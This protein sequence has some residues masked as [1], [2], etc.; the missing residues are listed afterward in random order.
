MATTALGLNQ[1]TTASGSQSD[2]TGVPDPGASKLDVE[3]VHNEFNRLKQ[4]SAQRNT[5]YYLLRQAVKGNFR[6]PRT[7]PTHIQK[8][9]HNFCK[10]ITERFAA[11][12]MSKGFDFTVDRPNTVEFRESAERAEK[13]LRKLFDL[14]GAPLQFEMGAKSG[15]QVGRTI[16]KVYRKGPKGAE[17]ACFSY[18]QPDYFYGVPAGTNQLG[19][20]ATVYYSYPIDI[21]TARQVYGDKPFKTEAELSRSNFYDLIPEQQASPTAVGLLHQRRVPVFEA[22]TNDYYLLEV[23]GVTIFNGKNPY[24]WSDTGEGFI[25][26]IVIENIRNSGD[27]IGEA[28]IEQVRELNEVYNQLVSRKNHIVGRWLTPTLVWEGA[29]SN[30]VQQLQS[31]IGG[32]GGL[33]TRIGSRL[34]FLEHASPNPQV[35]ELQQELRQAILESAGMNEIALQG[36]VQGS[37]NTGPALESQYQ[38]VLATID[39]KR[40]EWEG[41]LRLLCRMM[42]QVQE[43][44]GASKAL[45]QAVVNAS[46]DSQD[47]DGELVALSGKD[48]QGLRD[49]T[50]SWPGVLPKD[51]LGASRFELEKLQTGVQSIFTTMSNL[52]MD[53]PD[54]ELARMRDENADPQLK[55]QA[56][57]D[58]MKAQAQAQQAQAGAQS[59]QMQAMQAMQQMAMAQQ[60]GQQPQGG[61]EPE[62]TNT[63]ALPDE[64][65][66]LS[67][68]NTGAVIRELRRRSAAKFS[69]EGDQPEIQTA[70]GY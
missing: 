36:T 17:H 57:A 50:I 47:S 14:S 24:K 63:A 45:G 67:Q 33:S 10:A 70:A 12:L 51:D 19:E 43:D 26:Y 62:P 15:S 13:I 61:P 28:D 53:Y 6:W 18:C 20:Y 9:K 46:M 3:R 37:I 25:P 30:Y 27:G 64:R 16:Y 7:W 35:A 2:V 68:G 5:N 21:E 41:Q 1:Y 59:Q 23:G 40:K 55:G 31:V 22:W 49:V 32:G 56:V 58:Q 65:T 52:G 54:D 39:N 4:Q 38:P 29:P 42:L 44:I 48:I 8:L 11:L 60:Q 34:Y 69:D 66:L